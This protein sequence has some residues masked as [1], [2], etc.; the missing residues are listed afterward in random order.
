MEKAYCCFNSTARDFARI[1]QLV[2]NGGTW[3]GTRLIS[4]RYIK[5]ATSPASWLVDEENRPVDFYGYQFWIMHH[6]GLT[7]PCLRGI[8]GQYIFIIPQKNAVVVRLGKERSEAQK[9]HMREDSYEYVDAA[10]EL[11]K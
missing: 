7:I 11:M 10:L 5:A 1:G 4:E 9:N 3:R 6:R 2:L 8:H